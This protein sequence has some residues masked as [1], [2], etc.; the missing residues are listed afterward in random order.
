MSIA[1]WIKCARVPGAASVALW[2]YAIYMAHKPIFK[3]VMAPLAQLHID[4]DSWFGIA[5]VI[6][7]GVS[8]GWLL[9]R[10]IETPFMRLR[11][12]LYPADMPIQGASLPATATA[13]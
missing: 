11:A 12:R 3:V 13:V 9:Y 10:L 2:S 4:T 8:G 7:L 5:L 1:A 6:M